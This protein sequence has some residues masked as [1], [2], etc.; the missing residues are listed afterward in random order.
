MHR[1]CLPLIPPEERVPER[2]LDPHSISPGA[3]GFSCGLA[4]GGS[5][6]TALSLLV[7]GHS[8][9][10]VCMPAALAVFAVYIFC[11]RG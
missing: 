2:L 10:A 11:N 9:S 5:A 3:I 8:W 1:E 4:C 7:A 6:V